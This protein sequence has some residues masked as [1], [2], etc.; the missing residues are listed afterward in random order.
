M[1][2]KQVRLAPAEEAILVDKLGSVTNLLRVHVGEILLTRNQ[3]EP[4]QARV[5]V[6]LAA[7]LTA[8][9]GR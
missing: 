8:Q 1:T 4:K 5:D 2:R 6:G 9:A 7:A 3:V